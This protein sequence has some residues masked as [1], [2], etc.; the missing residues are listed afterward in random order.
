MWF[1]K[2]TIV[3]RFDHAGDTTG[4]YVK[5]L[6][7]IRDTCMIPAGFV[8]DSLFNRAGQGWHNQGPDSARHV[9][10][11]LNDGRVFLVYRGNSAGDW[12]S[13]FNGI[14]DSARLTNGAKL[15]IV[16][17][18]CC[19]SVLQSSSVGE[20]WL[21]AGSPDILKGAVG[22]IG[23]TREGKAFC[24][25]HLNRAFF[26]AI[27]TEDSLI[28]GHAFLRAKDSLYN[29]LSSMP[30]SQYIYY[31]ECNLLGDPT[32]QLWTE[33]PHPMIVEHLPAVEMGVP[34]MLVVSVKDS[35]SLEPIQGALV[36]LYK[37]GPT[38]PEV[39]RY[40]F[41]N[42]EGEAVFRN[43]TVPAPGTMFVT[44]TGKNRV[45]YQ[46][47]IQVYE[48]ITDNPLALA[49]NGNR[50]L[51]RRPNTEE[52][53]LVYTN[54]GKIVYRCLPNGDGNW[55]LPVSIGEGQFPAIA[56][57]CPYLPLVAWTDSIGGLWYG[58]KGAGGQWTVTH[59]YN[60]GPSDPIVNS[61]PSIADYCGAE[62][63]PDTVHILVTVSSRDGTQHWVR[64]YK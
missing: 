24:R 50:H 60:P 53:H 49:Y 55:S 5:D 20:R 61:P 30:D 56:L 48:M 32:L 40:E 14:P 29:A 26:K 34:V 7:Y 36:T 15:P 42:N 2:S 57:T 27:L 47:V 44:V 3:I 13:P 41:S 51:I 45:P 43:L 64:D 1:I 58:R 6:R 17:G 46:G 23:N 39:F 59:L 4:Y 22:Y 16:F 37:P 63:L 12:Y 35:A 31:V 38:L 18:G 62:G 28:L 9:I 25:H 33:V 54:D 52:F 8:V 19:T 21:R 10:D 11:A